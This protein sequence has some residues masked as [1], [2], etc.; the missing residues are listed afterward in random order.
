MPFKVGY[1]GAEIVGSDHDLPETGDGPEDVADGETEVVACRGDGDCE[2][3]G[4]GFVPA[5]AW[6]GEHAVEVSLGEL[7]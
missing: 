1:R 3:G 5:H 7:T 2:S 4:G 6:P